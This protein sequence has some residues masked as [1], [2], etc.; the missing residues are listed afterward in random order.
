MT[1]RR[2]AVALVAIVLVALSPIAFLPG[3]FDRWN[4]PK[5]V[6]LAAACI[7]AVVSVAAGRLPRWFAILVGAGAVLLAVAAVTGALPLAQ[8][9]GRWPRYEGL[10]TLPAY[11]AAAWIGARLLGP[12]ASESR[13]RVFVSALAVAAILAGCV[14]LLEAAGFRPISST[15]ARPGAL[16]GNASDQGVVGVMLVA[17]L[18]VPAMEA[19]RAMSRPILPTVGVAFSLAIVVS[20][21]SRA[22]ILVLG[23]VLIAFVVRGLVR[24]H[25]GE[26]I[27]AGAVLAISVAAVALEP[28]A[29][30]RVG[31]TSPLAADSVQSRL[32]NWFATAQLIA[33]HPLTGVGPSGYVDAIVP[34]HAST[35]AQLVGSNVTIDSPHDWLL[36]AAVAG[37]IPLLIVTIA[38]AVVVTIVGVRRVRSVDGLFGTAVAVAAFAVM[39]LVH[40]T[41]PA[42][43]ILASF[44]L[45]RLIAQPAAIV[46]RVRWV[47]GVAIAAWTALLVTTTLA[48]LP[49]QAGVAAADA[50]QLS[51][52]DAAFSTAAGLRSWDADTPSIAAQSFAG[53]ADAGVAG[54]AELAVRWGTRAV[55]RAPMSVSSGIALAVG[56][57]L[58]GDFEAARG[59]LER[60]QSFAPN[61][62]RVAHRLGGILFLLGDAEGAQEQLK[63]ATELDPGNVEVWTTFGY[64]C[65]KI[66]DGAGAEQARHMI[67]SLSR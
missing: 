61:D 54:A 21:A 40:F 46:D 29:R 8:L 34:F 14:S 43:T 10:V 12:A 16:F 26:A 13:R 44:L 25:R 5:L 32:D 49:L 38:L 42:T 2:D 11:V 35:W 64:V 45:G 39:L 36:Q 33:Q 62:P 50:G 41:A 7:L 19:W 27:A 30:S 24:R 9:M 4:L 59:T 52:A 63:R 3:A 60:M 58:S 6:V 31:G 37:G 23:V 51:T 17:V 66:G 22:A 28:L 55:D 67:A 47:V 53:A 20:S 56:Q 18:A 57:Q 1:A 65:D 48:E 15:L